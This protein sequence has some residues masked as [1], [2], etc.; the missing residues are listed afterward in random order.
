MIKTLQATAEGEM[1]MRKQR[2]NVMSL[3]TA[4]VL[5]LGV[6]GTSNAALVVTDLNTGG[7]D[8]GFAPGGSPNGWQGSGNVFITAASDLTYANYFISQSGTPGN[9]Y[10]CNTAHNDRM[11]SR[12][13]AASMS[14]DIWFTALVNV[15]AGAGFA[16]L[17]FDSDLYVSGAARY[18]HQLSELRVVLTSSALIVDMDGGA[19]PTATGT[20]TGTFAAGT[21]H[22][23]LGHL[24]V[25]AGNDTIEVW[26]DPDLRAVSGPGD[27]PGANFTSTTVD[28]M[29]S[30]A[31]IGVPLSWN[32][33]ASPHI[34]AIRLS[35]TASAFEDVTGVTGADTTEPEIADL[36]PTNTATNVFVGTDLVITFDEDVA[37]GTNGNV[38]IQQSAGGTFETIAV[39]SGAITVTGSNATINPSTDLANGTG[40]YIEIDAGAFTDLAA[41]SNEFAGISGSSTWSFTTEPPDLT[42]PSYT[43]LSP[44]NNAINVIAST[45]LVISFDE[46]VQ[47]GSTG[48]I[49]IQQTAGGTF[50]TIAVTSS[51]VTVSGSNVTINPSSNLDGGSSYYVE[52]DSGALED[53]SGNDFTGISG[54]GTWGFQVYAGT[55]VATD[56]NVGGTDTGFSGD[57]YNGSG[58]VFYETASDLTYGD[59][60]IMQ[61]GTTQRIYSSNASPDRQDLRNLTTA[62]SGEIW[63][64]VLAYVPTAADYAGLTFNSYGN[65]YDPITTDARI[66]MTPTQIQVGLNGGGAST[67]TG[68]FSADTTHLLLGKM[69]VVAGNDTISVWVDPDLTAVTGPGD[70]PAAN[71]TSTSIDFA[72]SITVIGAAGRKGAAAANTSIDAIWLSDRSTAFADVTGASGPDTTA[73]T[74]STLNPTNAATGVAIDADLVV[75]FDEDVQKGGSGNIVIQQSAGGTFE[76]IVVTSPNVTVSGADVTINPTGLLSGLTGYYVEIDSGAISDVAAT[77]NDFAGI[78]GSG[79]WSFTTEAA[80]VT[81]PSIV[82]LSPTNGATG[83][84]GTTDLVIRFDED[85]QKGASGNIVIRQSAGGTFETIAITSPNVTVS[86][87]NIT[88]NPS[89]SFANGAGYYVEIAAGAITDLAP[90]PNNFGGISGSGTWSFQ[91]ADG[92][93]IATDIN[94][95][96]VDTGFSGGWYAGS[97][98]AFPTDTNDLTYADYF[99]TQTGT[100][101]RVYASNSGTDRQDCRDLATALSGEIW[102]SALVHVPTGGDY[103]TL[104]F[105]P[106]ESHALLNY[107]SYRSDLRLWMTSSEIQVGFANAAATAGTGTFAPDTTHLLLG[108]MN[109]VGGNDT[110]KVWVDPNL[111]PAAFQIS[112]LPAANFTSTTVDFA[113]SIV[114]IGAGGNSGAAAEVHV[115]AIRLSNTATAFYDVTD[116]N[117]DPV[118]TVFMFR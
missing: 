44:T 82:T 98:N 101:E 84:A 81:A 17:S 108:Q 61:T 8:T 66:L 2:S 70:L 75:T 4:V 10:A 15:P 33:S 73:P 78:S 79:T 48:N 56:L 92:A 19:P 7:T 54:S 37:K 94:S 117:P 72:D 90:S 95:G 69:K 51:A 24:N 77:P 47:K 112:D 23:I 16:G 29:D 21:T 74:V 11:D 31:R 110:I 104:S 115:D 87:S 116:A 114:R 6:A 32:A 96:G 105:N 100:T 113:G 22:L 42:A 52:I 60:G 53:L 18:S 102:F 67:G 50:E 43:A 1:N 41:A 13:L 64:S 65:S 20:E 106:T 80:D 36:N 85:V 39:S 111:M 83:V 30:I 14:G 58:N 89:G 3:L 28:F 71:Y 45:D 26:I 49:V 57:F 63:F 97:N 9:V 86:G 55:L 40:Y 35:D 25:G 12:N 59:Y 99:L 62:M 27:L 109:V 93:F 91:V 68:T 88:I 76:T 34:D 38:V 118:A 5:T 46:D 107:E 103:A